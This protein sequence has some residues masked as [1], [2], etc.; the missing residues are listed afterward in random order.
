MS[1]KKDTSKEL[2]SAATSNPILVGPTLPP[3]PPFT[4]PT[5]ATGATGRICNNK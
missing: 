2:L 5:G 3:I 4:L 1:N